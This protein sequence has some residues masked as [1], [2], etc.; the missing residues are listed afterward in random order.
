MT[1]IQGKIRIIGGQWRSRLLTFPG[2]PDLR[3]T[4][5]RVRETIFNWL[6]QD[7]SG[8]RCLDLFAG[9]G[10]LGFEAASRGAA[11]VVMVDNDVQVYKALRENKER[12]QAMQVE[13]LLMN[14]LDFMQS[15]VRKFDVIFLDP[16]YRLDLLPQL[17][18]L[19][20]SHLE[21]DGLVYSEARDTWTPDKQWRVHRSAKAG[22]VRYQLLEFV[23]YG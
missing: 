9:S 22:T 10:A 12:L 16:P 15:D 19:L 20:S 1:L 5:N 6:E 4:A 14:A 11:H 3:P 23:H 2:H 13:L 18:S 8:L 17:M 21:E 7:L